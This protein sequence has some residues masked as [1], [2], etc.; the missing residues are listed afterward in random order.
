MV[1]FLVGLLVIQM[2]VKLFDGASPAD[3]LTA[4]CQKP[5]AELVQ[6]SSTPA[7][8]AGEAKHPNK[9]KADNMRIQAREDW[10]LTTLMARRH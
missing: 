7:A 3:Q 4:S 10:L 1:T 9:P 2:V 8:P 5:L 6:L